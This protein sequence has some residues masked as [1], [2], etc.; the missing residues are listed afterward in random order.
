M[1]T[2]VDPVFVFCRLS[3]AACG[4]DSDEPFT[5]EPPE[6]PENP[7]GND[8]SDEDD[9]SKPADPAPGSNGRYLD[10]VR[11]PQR[12]YRNVWLTRSESNLT[13]T[14]LK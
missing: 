5:P 6:Q 3:M 8:D 9:P 11:F 13:A 14:F 4:G 10:L 12:Q 2:I 7:G 1:K